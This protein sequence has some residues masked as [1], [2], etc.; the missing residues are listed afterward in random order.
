VGESLDRLNYVVLQVNVANR[1][2]WRLHSSQ[3]YTVKSAYNNL[4]KAK[5]NFNHV[6]WLKAIML[7]INIFASRLFLNIIPTK[8]NLFRRQIFIY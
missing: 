1:W 2:V 8:D 4:T 7:K 5:V 6:S 3:R